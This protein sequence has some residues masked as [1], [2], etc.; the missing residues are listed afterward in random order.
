ME[1]HRYSTF[2]LDVYW[3]AGAARDPDLEA[4]IIACERCRGY[5]DHLRSADAR[6]LVLPARPRRRTFVAAFAFAIAV[7]AGIVLWLR[8]TT[9]GSHQAPTYVA[10]KSA[11]AVQVL[12]RRDGATRLW[13]T[14]ARIREH[15]ALALRVACESMTHVVVLVSDRGDWKPTFESACEA[16]VLPFTLVVDDE[17]GD[18][19]VAVVLSRAPLDP[20]SARRAAEQQTKNADVWALMFVFGKEL[21]KP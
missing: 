8:G 13:D 21:S 11:P 20:A 15:D 12:V 4:H 3:A 17:P 1:N 16:D 19:R 10:T 14:N 7:A 2:A 18:E 5:L 9:E 6:E